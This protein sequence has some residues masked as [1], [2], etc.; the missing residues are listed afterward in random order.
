MRSA[1]LL[2]LGLLAAVNLAVIAC[3][4]GPGS[5]D[6]G[7]D[8]GDQYGG[9]SGDN[10]RSVQSGATDL[11][12]STATATA[13]TPTSQPPKDLAGTDYDQSCAQD[14]DCLAVY[15][16]PVCGSCMGCANVAI[17]GKDNGKYSTD[18]ASRQVQCAL[19]GQPQPATC[20]VPCSTTQGAHC[21]ANRCVFR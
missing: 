14:T 18:R 1:R 15:Q 2:G 17:N 6:E 19:A 8:T 4:G 12:E 7:G 16:G 13:T 20:G 11:P 5:A 9:V 10:G 3:T 21:D